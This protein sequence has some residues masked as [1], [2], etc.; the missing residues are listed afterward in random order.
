VSVLGAIVLGG[1][2]GTQ[3]AG[4]TLEALAAAAGRSGGDL[5]MVFR[6]VFFAAACCLA[7][8]L[9]CLL[10]MEERPLRGRSRPVSESHVPAE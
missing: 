7:V 1:A 8:G 6:W 3:N 5:A 2:G 4:V 9:V 10:A